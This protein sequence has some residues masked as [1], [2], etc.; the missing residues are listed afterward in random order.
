MA[1]FGGTIKLEGEQA[2]RQALKNIATDLQKVASQQKLTA[3]TYEKSDKSLSAIS[4]RS[5]DLTSKKIRPQF[6]TSKANSIKR[7]Q[8]LKKSRGNMARTP[9]N[10]KSKQR[11]STTSKKSLKSLILNTIKTSKRLKRTKRRRPPRKPPS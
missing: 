5:Q 10:I 6:K 3:A 11:S 1:G 4:Q 8:S 9:K 2:Y 7:K